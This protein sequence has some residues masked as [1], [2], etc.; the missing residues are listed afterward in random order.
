MGEVTGFDLDAQQVL[1][2]DGEAPYDSLIV[3]TG[4]RHSYF[5]NDE[6]E[7]LAPGLKTIEDAL[8]IRRRIFLAFEEAEREPDPE[9]RKALADLRGRGWRADRRRTGRR[10]RR[11]RPADAQGQLPPHQPGRSARSSW[12]RA[13]TGCSR[14]SRPSCRAKRS[15]RSSGWA[16]PSRPASRVT[17]I[18]GDCVTVEQNGGRK[19]IPTCTVLWAAGVQAS[20]LAGAGRG[21]PAR[22]STAAAG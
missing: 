14:R 7:G 9:R 21:Q 22:R 15:A 19:T 5:G 8:D 10:A 18:E 16:S 3:A 13:R 1:L 2:A 11:D 20:P 4:S 12:S 6:W 17:D